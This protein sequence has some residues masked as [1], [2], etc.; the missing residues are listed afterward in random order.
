LLDSAAKYAKQSL[1]L[2]TALKYT[3]GI[4][5]SNYKLHLVEL[6]K[7]NVQEATAYVILFNKICEE[8]GYEARLGKG[9]YSYGVILGDQGETD[10]SLFYIHKSLDINLKLNDTMRLIATNNAIGNIYSDQSEFD[11]AVYYYL[12]SAQLAELS[13]KLNYLG[14]IYNNVGN[15]FYQMSEY[16]KASSYLEQALEINQKYEDIELTAVS[17]TILGNNADGAGNYTQAIYYYNQA[18]LLFESIGDQIGKADILNNFAS[19]YRSQSKLEEA[20]TSYKM[21]H[22]IYVRQNYTEGITIT[23][24]NIGKVYSDMGKYKLAGIYLDS[25][26]RISTKSGYLQNRCS[27]L[28]AISDNYYKSGEYKKAYD[29][30]IMYSNLSDSLTGIEKSKALHELDK[31]YQ[32]EKD[33]ARILTLEKENLEKTMQRNAGIYS[34]IG[35]FMLAGFIVIY[36]LQKSKKDRIIAMQKIIQLEEEKKLMAA[37]IL[38]EGQ[39]E[40]RK[41]I[42]QELHD[43]LGVLLSAT[44]MQFTSIKDKSPENK[45]LIEKATRML[46]QASGDVRKISHNMM[47]G[48]LTKLGF[49]EA[50]ED[51]MESIK[52][53]GD[54]NAVMETEGDTDRLPENKEIMLYRVVQ[55][56]VNNTLKHAN[57]KSIFLKMARFPDRLEMFFSDDGIGFETEKAMNAETSSLG[58]NSILSRIGF[59]NGEVQIDSSPGNGTRYKI[60]IPL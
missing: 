11:S 19:I 28:F 24:M 6:K 53:A 41:R 49:F 4:A 45:P 57:A 14:H 43:G 37:K 39:E 20:L 2:S 22:Q 17:L 30:Y 56:M 40:E 29:S 25:C 26:L 44:K 42:A 51:L 12:K 52:D 27:V 35:I 59:L 48:L 47:P 58:L 21:A 50:V 31:K 8:A 10:S 32:K 7:G 3:E 18:R 23:L 13:G 16:V 60:R 36:F 34:A 55:E 15:T 54:I 33:Q 1:L 9:Y 46:E 5:E 38:L